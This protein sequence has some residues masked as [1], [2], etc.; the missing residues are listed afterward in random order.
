MLG[1]G[2]GGE[3]GVVE[4]SWDRLDQP[5]DCWVNVKG[6]R[7]HV[8]SSTLDLSRVALIRKR[9]RFQFSRVHPSPC[10]PAVRPSVRPAMHH[11]ATAAPHM[12]IAFSFPIRPSGRAVRPSDE[13][14][15]LSNNRS[16]RKR[17]TCPFWSWDLWE[18]EGREDGWKEGR[19]CTLCLSSA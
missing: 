7:R 8:A 5:P 1:S 10:L 9:A 3:K 11:K 16:N 19:H 13:S 15:S 12:N 4:W 18:W 2:W 17:A 6:G 14:V